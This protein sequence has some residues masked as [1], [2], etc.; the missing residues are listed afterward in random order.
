MSCSC[1]KTAITSCHKCGTHVCNLCVKFN[2]CLGHPDI[3]PTYA[4]ICRP[5]LGYI[6]WEPDFYCSCGNEARVTCH[7]CGAGKC[8]LCVRYDYCKGHPDIYATHAVV[9][10]KHTIKR[11]DDNSPT[12]CVCVIL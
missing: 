9:C 11:R 10:T 5:C 3:L 1:G 7:M 12:C 4:V 2:I 6:N 8:R